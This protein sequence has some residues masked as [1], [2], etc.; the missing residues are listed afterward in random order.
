MLAKL[1]VLAVLAAA[2]I[3]L[4]LLAA[5]RVTTARVRIGKVEKTFLPEDKLAQYAQDLA[6]SMTLEKQSGHS[7]LKANAR[8]PL[9]LYHLRLPPAEP[10][11]GGRQN[12]ACGR[13]VDS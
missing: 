6:D 7:G 1:L 11:R 12:A 13:R 2:F 5:R 10:A 9:C 3:Q 4:W 8:V